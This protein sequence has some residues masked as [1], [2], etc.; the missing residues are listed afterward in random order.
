MEA[1]TFVPA[2]AARRVART[3][4]AG[5]RLQLAALVSVSFV[6]HGLASAGHRT[7]RIFPDEYIYATL[8]RSL[9]LH[10]ILGIR[11]GTAHFPA[12]L[13]PLAAAPIW[14]LASVSTAYRLVQ[15]ENALFLSLAAVPAYLLARRLRLTHRYALLCAVFAVSLPGLLRSAF[16]M[17]GSLAY[18]LVLF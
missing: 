5:S 2:A 9:G 15:L 17:A 6:V 13:A 10:G 16:V 4:A 14:A 7:P 18:P 8:G 1:S 3:R 11:G 12:V